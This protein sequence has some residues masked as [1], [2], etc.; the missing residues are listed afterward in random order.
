MDVAVGISAGKSFFD[1]SVD[2]HMGRLSNDREIEVNVVALD[3]LVNSG[4]IPPPNIIKMDVEGA[5]FEALSGMRHTMENFPPKYIFLATHGAEVHSKCCELLWQW[6]YA[7]QSLDATKPLNLTD[8]I[9]AVK[10]TEQL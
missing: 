10:M 9:L 6:G 5:E 1:N 4:K 3:A 8:E 7:I 2:H